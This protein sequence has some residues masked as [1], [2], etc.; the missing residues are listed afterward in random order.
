MLCGIA[1]LRVGAGRLTLVVPESIAGP[2]AIAVPEAGVL[3][4]GGGSGELLGDEAGDELE[5]ADAVVIGPGFVDPGTALR[6][7]AEVSTGLG[8]HTGLVLDAFALGVLPDLGDH[9]LPAEAVLTPNLVEAGILLG[10]DVQDAA[11]GVVE[12]ADRYPAAVTCF[13]E[14]ARDGDRWHV[15]GGGSGLGTSGSG[16][17]LAGAVAGLLARGA[18]AAQAAVW[19]TY[20][21]A[22][23]GDRLSAR[24]GS[25]GYLARELADELSIALNAVG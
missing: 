13:G 3:A 23:A 14:V 21:H 9:V 16:D 18:D 1:A 4:L 24:I 11:H 25:V 20:A 5:S 10:R 17:V 22:M 2:V 6:A 19:A 15:E 12:I 8:A 7:V